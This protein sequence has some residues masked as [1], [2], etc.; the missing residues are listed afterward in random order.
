MDNLLYDPIFRIETA[1][2]SECLSLPALFVELAQDK[3]ESFLG[4]QR[5]QEDAFHVFLCYLAGSVLAH[6]NQIEADQ[7]E[8]FWRNGLLQLAQGQESAWKLLVENP[9][10]PGFMQPSLTDVSI[11]KR[12]D[13]K[14]NEGPKAESPDQLDLLDISR[15]HDIKYKRSKHPST[16][17]WIYSL[18]SLQTCTCYYGSGNYGTARINGTTAR[19]TI[20]IMVSERWG[21]RWKVNTS[22]LLQ[23]RNKLLKKKPYREKHGVV[24]AWLPPWDLTSS[25]SL[26]EMDP[27]FIE[28][29]RAVRLNST[30]SR[31]IVLG[32]TS[33]PRVI[34]KAARDEIK[35]NLGDPWTPI[36]LRSGGAAVFGKE[37]F[38]V[39]RLHDLI[40]S[41]IDEESLYSPCEFMKA[42]GSSDEIFHAT[43]LA[44]RGKT[45]NTEG[46]HC[47]DI[48]IPGQI[49]LSL[50]QRDSKAITL[51]KISRS[52]IRDAEIMWRQVL[53]PALYKLLDGGSKQK[54]E[55]I[56][57]W[58]MRIEKRLKSWLEETEKAYNSAWTNDYF[59]LLWS[60]DISDE[61]ST[62]QE[63]LAFL[64]SQAKDVLLAA[65]KR[66]PKRSGRTYRSQVS[67]E[68]L[69]KLLYRLKLN[70]D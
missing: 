30:G 48:P 32:A 59:M 38:T 24:L 41:K 65:I 7:S 47:A 53:K 16:E 5:H 57:S 42:T 68:E 46:F 50:F 25:L 52:R 67:A 4:L 49:K 6:Q 35:G 15:N 11:F 23:Y 56:G 26:Q 63:W 31:I 1:N 3:V 54:P 29:S 51:G 9:L 27:F 33:K 60:A 21:A 45:S 19:P 39:Q 44:R 20:E 64:E 43:A 12:F 34:D 8:E 70:S 55:E 58:Q 13:F 2:A 37:G 62:Q 69:F 40:F 18:I 36:N 61:K 22:R 17:Q 14:P 10:E 28:I 66:F